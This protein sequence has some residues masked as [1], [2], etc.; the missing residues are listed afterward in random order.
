[1][2]SSLEQFRTP[3]PKL[4]R[5]GRFE[6]VLILRTC[7][8]AIDLEVLHRLQ[9]HLKAIHGRKLGSKARDELLGAGPALL[10]RFEDD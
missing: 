9:K 6:G 4:A 10:A 7:H 1:M 2:R 5:V 3:G 8:S